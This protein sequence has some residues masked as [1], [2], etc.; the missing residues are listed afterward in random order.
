ML[1]LQ[2]EP[3]SPSHSAMMVTEAGMG[4]GYEGQSPKECLEEQARKPPCGG[5][6][7]KVKGATA[8]LRGGGRPVYLAR[9]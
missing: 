8:R 9:R 3:G 4:S 1:T 6:P 5:A 2:A 7:I